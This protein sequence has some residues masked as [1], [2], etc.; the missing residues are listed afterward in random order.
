[1]AA[2]IVQG[3][4]VVQRGVYAAGTQPVGDAPQAELPELCAGG[5]AEQCHGGGGHAQRCDPPGAEA[6]VEPLACKAGHDSPGGDDHRDD[7]RPGNTRPKLG[8][9]GGPRRTQQGI[10]QTKADERQIDDR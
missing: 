4:I 8:V 9:H 2:L 3:H 1:M 7:T 10:R 5:K 6:G